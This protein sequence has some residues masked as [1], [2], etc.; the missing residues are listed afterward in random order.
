M[1]KNNDKI[2]NPLD[3]YKHPSEV[4]HDDELNIEDKVKLLINWLDDIKLRQTAESENMPP[5]HESRFYA[6]DVERFLHKYQAKQL[7][8]K[9]D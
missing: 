7:G 8:E 1:N 5:A 9:E 3:Y 6:A 2:A 4:D